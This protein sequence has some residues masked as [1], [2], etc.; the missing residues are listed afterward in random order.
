MEPVRDHSR[1]SG[2]IRGYI[3]KRCNSW[4]EALVNKNMWGHKVIAESPKFEWFRKLAK[5]YLK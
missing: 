5:E 3:H 2:N 4:I 1:K